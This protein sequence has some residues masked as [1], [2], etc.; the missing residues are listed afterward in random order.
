VETGGARTGGPEAAA[1]LEDVRADIDRI[2]REIVRLLGERSRCVR[3]AA[4]FKTDESSVRA[5][6]RV[7]RM[8]A[9]RRAW[10]ADEALSPDFVEALFRAVT[11]HFIEHELSH[12]RGAGSGG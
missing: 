6:D 4:R 2:D 12:W 8:A 9:D 7:R 5:P 10:A 3:Q 11:D 1:T